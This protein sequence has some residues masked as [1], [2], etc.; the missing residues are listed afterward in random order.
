MGGRGVSLYSIPR[1]IVP[2]LGDQDLGSGSQGRETTCIHCTMYS[3]FRWTCIHYTQMKMYIKI[4]DQAPMGRN[5]LALSAVLWSPRE[6]ELED[7]LIWYFLFYTHHHTCFCDLS[8]SSFLGTLTTCLTDS[9]LYV[10]SERW[11]VEVRFLTFNSQKSGLTWTVVMELSELC[12]KFRGHH[13]ANYHSCG[14]SSERTN[15]KIRNLERRIIFYSKPLFKNG[16]LDELFLFFSFFLK[17][18]LLFL[19]GFFFSYLC[20]ILKARQTR[21]AIDLQTNAYCRQN[22]R[23]K[24]S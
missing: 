13:P 15:L 20:L 16:Q 11:D 4:L 14:D 1:G 19:H 24:N 10:D 7:C 18:S 21:Q 23:M 17:S 22:E 6:R 2:S 12:W 3:V 5:H 9:R 8:N